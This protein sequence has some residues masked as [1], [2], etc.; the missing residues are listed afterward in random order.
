VTQAYQQERPRRHEPWEAVEANEL[1]ARVGAPARTAMA[2]IAAIDELGRGPRAE[3]DTRAS[4]PARG[5]GRSANGQARNA[6]AQVPKPVA[7]KAPA[8]KAQMQLQPTLPLDIMAHEINKGG[9]LLP[10]YAP[11]QCRTRPVRSSW[12]VSTSPICVEAT[13]S[14]RSL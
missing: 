13:N 11:A 14:R 8:D 2:T 12:P 6:E 1:P 7:D 3:A 4:A 5:G 9:S 10:A